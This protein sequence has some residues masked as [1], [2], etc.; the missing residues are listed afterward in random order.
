MK[1]LLFLGM[2]IIL[3]P[4]FAQEQYANQTIE[5]ILA[6]PDEEIDLGI[7]CLILAKDAYTDLKI[8][9]FDYV[10]N[11]MVERINYLMQGRTDPLVRISML[12]SYLY[13]RGWWNDSITFTYDLD[14]L[15]AAKKEN[16]Y[17]SAYISTKKG[18]CITMPMLYLVLADRLGW[19]I[20]AVR[21]PKHFFC[22]YEAEGFDENNIDPTVGGGYSS[23]QKYVKD[24]GITKKPIENGVYLRTLT[25]KEY[26]AS[27]LL[28]N[29]RHFYERENNLKRAI[30]LSYL[31]LKYDSTLSSAHW[32]IGSIYY[33]YARQLEKEMNMQIRAEE[34]VLNSQIRNQNNTAIHPNQKQPSLNDRITA[35]IINKQARFNPQ[36]GSINIDKIIFDHF[37]N[38]QN[39]NMPPSPNNNSHRRNYFVPEIS[40]I[41]QR[42]IP[43]INEAIGRARWH[44]EKAEELGIVL[45]FPKE[46]FRLQ[47]KDIE[48]FRR[49]GEY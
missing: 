34:I 19:P 29:A 10:I 44:R 36:A 31:A 48:E 24:F 49:T 14:D 30:Q 8:E 20:K 45:E 42:Y 15:E 28:N 26:L 5:E 35:E 1:L 38:P 32:N 7:A 3:I 23:N 17:L 4:L 22:R 11:Y 18:S 12:N 37:T 2:F 43:Q 13:R 6:L 27:L 40:S 9:S 41:K 21:A 47:Q 16:Q 25:K 39:K 46:F 33:N